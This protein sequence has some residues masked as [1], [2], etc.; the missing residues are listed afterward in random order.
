MGAAL[1][2]ASV[3]GTVASIDQSRKASKAQEKSQKIQQKQQA[4][5]TARER[6]KQYRAARQAQAELAATAFAQGTSATSRTAS[7]GGSIQQEAATNV[8]FLNQ[9]EGFTSAIGQQNIKSVQ[10]SNRAGTYSALAGLA[11]QGAQS[12][13]FDGG[14]TGA[15]GVKDPNTGAIMS[16]N[17][18]SS[19]NFFS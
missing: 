15:G 1:I 5:Q 4:M 7:I 3:L 16:P 9:S 17:P 6:R 19:S 13:L 2:I 11:M 18:S 10:A 8:G 14:A 12:G